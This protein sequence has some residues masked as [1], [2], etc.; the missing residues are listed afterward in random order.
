M[1]RAVLLEDRGKII[2]YRSKGS[3]IRQIASLVGC[4]PSTVQRT[5]ERFNVTGNLRDRPRSGRKA[6]L[7]ASDDRYIL[8]CS[9][10]DRMKS[11]PILTNEFNSSRDRRVSSSTVRRSLLKSK[12]FGRVAAKK[13]LLRRQNVKKRLEFARNHVN[14][15]LEQWSRV[16]FTDESKFELF[17]CKRR[18][19]VRRMM[20]ERFQKNCIV[21]TVKHGGG[22]VMVWGGVCAAGVIPL[23][24]IKGI[25]DAK[26][27]HSILCR[28]ALPGGIKLLGRGF[29]FQQDNDPKHTA[30]LNAK[31]LESKVKSGKLN[32]SFLLVLITWAL[33]RYFVITVFFNHHCNV[34]FFYVCHFRCD[35]RHAM[36]SSE[37]GSQSD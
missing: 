7:T 6:N 36:A 11:V 9:K 19:F 10:R 25:M 34:G 16:L 20:N 26:Y 32:A 2:A 22:S 23:V 12:M 24:R 3:S 14:W 5:I 29:T 8:I 35:L 33:V 15:T 28:K 30:K 17:G 37:P 4:S 21:P 18:L 13:P 1:V 31:Y 27:Y